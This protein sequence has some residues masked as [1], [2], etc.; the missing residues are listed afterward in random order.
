MLKIYNTMTRKKEEFQPLTEGQ[1]HMYVC[2]PTVYNYIHIGNA[3]STVAF[4]V[5]R[6]YLEFLGYEVT[7]VSNFTD[8]DDKIIKR[9]QE[10]K[11]SSSEVADKYIAAYYADTD[12]LGVKRA[13]VNPRVVD[14]MNE[15]IAFVKSLEDKGYAYELDGDVYY[16]V[17]Q[18]RAY[19]ELSDQSLADLREGASER[20][21]T[22]R[23]LK[24]EDSADFALWKAAKPGEPA[25]E[26]PWG[27]GRPGWHI[28]CSVMSTKYLGDTF[29]IHGGGQDLI[30]PH[31]ENEI[32]Q[33]EAKTG[34]TFARYW[35]HNGFVT[36]GNDGEKMSKSLGN[37]VLVH[38]LI[39]KVDPAIVRFFLSNAQYRSPLKFSEEALNDAHNNLERLNNAYHTLTYR[40]ED[41]KDSLA[42]DPAVLDS[43]GQKE[44]AFIEAMNDDFNVPNGLTV[45]YELMGDIN[46]Y[47][48]RLEVSTAV[49]S[50]YQ[51]LYTTL[52]GIFG[53]TFKQDELLDEDIQ[54]LIDERTEA[55]KNKDFQKSDAIRDQLKEQGVL[56]D[57]TPQGTRWKRL[58]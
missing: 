28:E 32:A 35:M 55:R 53:V 52:A 27:M 9:S 26:S 6:R 25:W 8:V 47:T 48:E 2:G 44:T 58:S 10:E 50:A 56:L 42:D 29:D 16:R 43:M 57:D 18:F 20:V 54:R 46:R 11:I 17:R 5:I 49:L 14:N 7:Y 45:L 37:F 36:M 13:T 30:F 31:H 38:D 33:S 40:M 34:Q 41:A 39:Q 1:V 22:D 3:R 21:Q 19:G 24:K 15:I 4:D 23:Q 51:E 12:A